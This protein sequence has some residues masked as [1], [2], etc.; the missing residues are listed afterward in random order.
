MVRV[1]ST[2][3]APIGRN[4]VEAEGAVGEQPDLGVEAFHAAVGEAQSDR[5]E[6]AVA[7]AAD[8]AGELDG[9]SWLREAQA[10]QAL[11]WSGARR[12]SSRW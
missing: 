8:R 1:K 11:R 5:G 4:A 12:G 7:V 6:D 2:S 9:L 3:S 10:S